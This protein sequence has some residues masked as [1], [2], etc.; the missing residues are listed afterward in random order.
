MVCYFMALILGLQFLCW[1]LS[2]LPLLEIEYDGAIGPV[3]GICLK[4]WKNFSGCQLQNMA[5]W[6]YLAQTL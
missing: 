1:G 2:G 6:P 5:R 3:L 4:T